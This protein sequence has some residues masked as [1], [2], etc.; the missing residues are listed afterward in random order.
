MTEV[1]PVNPDMAR[2]QELN[3]Q[4]SSQEIIAVHDLPNDAGI[5]LQAR[6]PLRS[7]VQPRVRCRL[8]VCRS[9]LASPQRD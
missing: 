6:E 7:L 9:R 5:K 3:S 1:E 2:I 4:R 8:A